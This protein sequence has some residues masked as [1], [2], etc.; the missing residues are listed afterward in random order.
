MTKEYYSL[1]LKK[2]RTIKRRQLKAGIADI[3]KDNAELFRVW[4]W[5][6]AIDVDFVKKQARSNLI[7]KENLEKAYEAAST[8]TPSEFELRNYLRSKGEN[9]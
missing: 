2:Y 3:D 9:V 7:Q 5:D 6:K 1:L 8:E 4:V